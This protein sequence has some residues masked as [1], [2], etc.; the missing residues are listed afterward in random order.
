MSCGENS[1]ASYH[2]ITPTCIV[3][4]LFPWKRNMVSTRVSS[5]LFSNFTWKET[6]LIFWGLA[7]VKLRSWLQM[8]FWKV[9]KIQQNVFMQLNCDVKIIG[10]VKKNKPLSGLLVCWLIM[11]LGERLPSKF[12]ICPW[13]FASRTNIHFS[14]NLSARDII[15]WHNSCLKGFILTCLFQMAYRKEFF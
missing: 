12:H 4:W 15:S 10:R 13:T 9:Q 5:F 2:L 1:Q 8:L 6:K 7:I 3:L 11:S 14:D